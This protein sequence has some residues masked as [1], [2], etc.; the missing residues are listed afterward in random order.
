M[1]KVIFLVILVLTLITLLLGCSSSEF[2]QIEGEK[3]TAKYSGNES[4]FVLADNGQCTFSSS[5][6]SS[7]FK[8][9]ILPSFEINESENENNRPSSSFEEF[10]VKFETEQNVVGDYVINNGRFTMTFK[11][12]FVSLSII[13][14][15]KDVF[16]STAKENYQQAYDKG[17]L[18]KEEYQ[19]YIDLLDGKSIN[20]YSVDDSLGKLVLTGTINE[21]TNDIQVE[22]FNQ[23]Y[24]N[25]QLHISRKYNE[26][27]IEI[28]K[29]VFAQDGT[30]KSHHE[31]YDDGSNKTS[32]VYYDD[33]SHYNEEWFRENGRLTKYEFLFSDGYKY[34]EYYNDDE[35]KVRSEEYHA[36]GITTYRLF[37]DNGNETEFSALTGGTD[38]TILV[39]TFIVPNGGEPLEALHICYDLD[40]NI[41]SKAIY[42]YNANYVLIKVTEYDEN[43]DI[44]TE[45]RYDTQGREIY[46][47]STLEEI[48]IEITYDAEDADIIRHQYST[49]TDKLIGIAKEKDGIGFYIMNVMDNGNIYESFNDAANGEHYSLKETVM[50]ALGNLIKVTENESFINSNGELVKTCPKTVSEY[51]NGKLSKITEYYNEYDGNIFVYSAIKKISYYENGIFVNSEEFE[52]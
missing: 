44:I 4:G 30:A 20:I 40:L 10:D 21:E 6:Q 18:S 19:L 1:K 47:Y 52:V 23:F 11:K 37:D 7:P 26:N 9:G 17:N 49:K 33:G 27:G 38:E 3:Y 28:K 51:K 50:D 2:Q 15:D 48:R 22:E 16:I 14:V 43:N 31:Y 39:T 46:F 45:S 34:T 5:D 13:G 12:N 24:K 8:I 29:S 36:N 42:E 41:L 32:V 25:D 35:I